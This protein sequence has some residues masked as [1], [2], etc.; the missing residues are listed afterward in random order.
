MSFYPKDD[1]GRCVM[2]K[3][4]QPVTDLVLFPYFVCPYAC[5]KYWGI[6]LMEVNCEDN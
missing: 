4:L 6:P 3:F 1:L 5:D 2:Y